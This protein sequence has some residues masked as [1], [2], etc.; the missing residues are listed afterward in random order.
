MTLIAKVNPINKEG[1]KRK[2]FFDPNYNPQFI[3]QEQ[4]LPHDLLFYGEIQD[5]Y[6]NAAQKVL[7]FITK[8][9]G[10]HQTYVESSTDPLLSRED[11]EKYVR[12]YLFREKIEKLVSIK[13]S[14]QAIARTS[15][16]A[17][18][19][20][21]RLPV[22]YRREGLVGMLNHD[23][24]THFFR[25]MNDKKQVWHGKSH[26]FHMHPYTVTEEGLAVLNGTLAKKDKLLRVQ[27][28]RY[29][30]VNYAA[31]HSFSQL[32]TALIPYEPRR[33]R[34]WDL[35]LRAKRGIKD[36]SKPGAFSKDQTYF[37]GSIEVWK[38]LK[39]NDFKVE[40]L[41]VGKIA[42]ED[43]AMVKPIA[44]TEGLLIPSFI[45]EASKTYR[46]EILAVGKAN[47][48]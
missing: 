13:F 34:R 42:V 10:S 3:Y 17:N 46:E 47:F 1:E 27:A 37:A 8:A 36:T 4:V 20:T 41:Y 43:M 24:G 16:S 2:F 38:W 45:K 19:L 21:I 11:V 14:S 35:C 28:L 30:A 25:T 31:S 33:E 39:K 23:V 22:E 5:T 6:L 40:Q 26:E 7:D 29:F 48:F 15:M 18:L 44:A 9:Y 32:N 12:E